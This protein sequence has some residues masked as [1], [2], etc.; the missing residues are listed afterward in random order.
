MITGW[1]ACRLRRGHGC[2]ATCGDHKQKEQERD[3][4]QALPDQESSL[5]LR[6]L[7]H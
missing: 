1:A 5:A 6:Q 7:S 4:D 3:H 2:E